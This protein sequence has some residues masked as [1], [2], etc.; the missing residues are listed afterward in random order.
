MEY[1]R[2]LEN[3]VR[4]YQREGIRVGRMVFWWGFLAG[5]AL[6]SAV[7]FVIRSRR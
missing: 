4:K 1:V 6:M 7:W 3:K 5:S 2:D